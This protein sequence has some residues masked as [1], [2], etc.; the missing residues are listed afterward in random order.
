MKL[1]GAMVREGVE[2]GTKLLAAGRRET[3]RKKLGCHLVE[4]GQT[5]R[6]R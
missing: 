1:R 5:K 6:A 4:L 2:G 3:L